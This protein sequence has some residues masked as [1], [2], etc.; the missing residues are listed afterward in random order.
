M[1]NIVK[2]LGTAATLSSIVACGGG[3]DGDNSVRGTLGLPEPVLGEANSIVVSNDDSQSDLQSLSMSGSVDTQAAFDLTINN[4][5]PQAAGANAKSVNFQFSVTDTEGATLPLD[6]LSLALEV[7]ATGTFADAYRM[8]L[9]DIR[10]ADDGGV[11]STA[12]LTARGAAT[13][14]PSGTY[15]ARVVVNPNWQ[16]AF[17][18]VP[19]D[20]DHSKPFRYVDER[21][22][23][24]NASNTFQIQVE[25]TTVCAEDSF[26][27]NDD[28]FSASEIPTGGEINASLCLDDVDF[29]SVSLGQG[30]STSLSFSYTDGDSNPNPSTRYVLLDPD[31]TLLS[32]PQVA[33]STNNIEIA[34]DQAGAYYLALFGQ[35]SSYRMTREPEL[36]AALEPGVASDFSNTR[37][38]TAETIA[39]PNSWL[40]GDIT[41]RKLLFSEELL[42]GQVV[43]CGRITTQFR[44]EFPVAYITP[45]H[46]ADNFE[47]R[48][49]ADGTYLIDGEQ[50]AGWSTVNGD[51]SNADW[52]GNDFPG[53]AER[54]SDYEWRYWSNDG[55]SYVECTLE[56]NQ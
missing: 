33:R 55:L 43:N 20:S 19:A 25:N 15:L 52:Y 11:G 30:Q 45:S 26:E 36:G 14:L 39:G 34:A 38:F 10:A 41:L 31:F 50:E 49:L 28:V 48:F 35:R 18:S 22:Y 1:N 2:A 54:V 51:I 16:N 44:G 13:D 9:F 6:D 46:F 17:D 53:Y 47:F 23:S 5:Q 8:P 3:G 37:I 32:S 24:N 29:Y 12:V 40:L 42:Y 21:D 7:A 4:A 27:D 56:F